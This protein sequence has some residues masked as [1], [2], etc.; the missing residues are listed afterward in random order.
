MGIP[1]LNENTPAINFKDIRQKVSK[2]KQFDEVH[3]I[4][5]LK[6]EFAFESPLEDHIQSFIQARNCITHERGIVT[7]ERCNNTDKFVLS[8]RRIQFEFQ[9]EDGRI[10]VIDPAHDFSANG[11]PL[12][13][14]RCQW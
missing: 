10:D 3:K 11:Y 12:H 9:S 1:I 6:K 8:W 5:K 13:T 2:V 14:R 7:A 4:K